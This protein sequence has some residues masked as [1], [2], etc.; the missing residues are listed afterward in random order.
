M[1]LS[2]DEQCLHQDSETIKK[3]EEGFDV[4]YCS[5]AKL[6]EFMVKFYENKRLIYSIAV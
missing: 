4:D 6:E 1:L 2:I 5:P 3:E